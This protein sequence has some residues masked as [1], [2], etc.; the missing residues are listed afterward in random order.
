MFGK[1]WL[2]VWLVLVCPTAVRARDPVPLHP[3]GRRLRA[4]IDTLDVENR[5]LAGQKINWR[6]GR[7]GGAPG[8]RNPR[9][10]CSA[11]VAAVCRRLDVP[12]LEPPPRMYLSNRQHDWLRG[13]GQALGWRQVGAVR[14]QELANQGYLVV[15]SWKNREKDRYHRGA[16]HIAVVRPQLEDIARIQNR[17]PQITQ[18]GRRNYRTTSVAVGFRGR[19]WAKRQ[20]LYFAYLRA[21]HL[22]A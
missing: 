3:E 20:V 16:G 17:G 2:I 18:A 14:A 22:S 11:F 5:W 1:H 8:E 13:R 10:H 21:N 12:M 4:L 19:A 6:T 7:A 9:T 15:A